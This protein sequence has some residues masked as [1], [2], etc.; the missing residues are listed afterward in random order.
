[1]KT[2]Y[3]VC[4]IETQ[5]GLWYKFNGEFSGLIHDQFNFCM[6][7]QLKM[8]FDEELVGYL[9][10]TDSLD[11]LFEWFPIKDIQELE[12]H[13]YSICAYETEDFKF[14]ERFQHLVINQEKSKLV[15]KIS[16]KEAEM[17]SL[18]NFLRNGKWYLDGDKKWY[19]TKGRGDYSQPAN[20][21]TDL[22][23]A[24]KFLT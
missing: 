14:Y 23:L 20:R 19:S 13:G 1:M 9:S 2:F 7:N 11:K 17:A 4:N 18:L 22:E 16:V 15:E 3:R 12:K 21:H 6:H 24:R 5:Q 10:V 8:D